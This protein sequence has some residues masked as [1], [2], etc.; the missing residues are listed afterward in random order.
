MTINEIF[1]EMFNEQKRNKELEH[2]KEMF[3]AVIEN[4][5]YS[6]DDFEEGMRL[7]EE[8]SYSE[9]FCILKKFAD[10][11]NAQA[12]YEI[13]KLLNEG[14][15]VEKNRE[16]SKKYLMESYKQGF[17][18][19]GELLRKMRYE[20]K[21]VLYKKI[22][23]EYEN[24][25]SDLGYSIDVPN[26]W[27]KLQS[28]NKKCFDTI[29]IDGFDGD[30]IF[31]IKM[32]V[33]LIEIPYNMA[34]SVSLDRVANN[35]GCIESVEFNNGNCEG[36]LICGEGIDG[37]CDYIFISKGRRGVYDLR[38]M[39]DKYLEPE[40]ED[41]IDHIVYSFKIEDKLEKNKQ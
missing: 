19:S 40:Y 7:L 34:Y 27:M 6:S 16:K 36:R 8:E 1:K 33:F 4:K 30:V 23:I 26:Q 12:Q 14:L 21:G 24:K 11:N 32:Q 25:V 35:M 20:E 10:E 37:T 13:G 29:A 31:N 41:I 2:E 15:G 22:E 3:K 28:K 18:K 9:A 38:I 5:E 39:V 17:K